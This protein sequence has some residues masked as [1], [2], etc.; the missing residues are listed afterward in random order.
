MEKRKILFIGMVFATILF[1]FFYILFNKKLCKN[2]C[3]V[4][5]SSQI[6]ECS[7]I[8]VFVGILFVVA[9]ASLYIVHMKIEKLKTDINSKSKSKNK[10]LH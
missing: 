1:G 3:E 5:I 4:C 10:R 2:L 8:F 6:S 9:G 7:M